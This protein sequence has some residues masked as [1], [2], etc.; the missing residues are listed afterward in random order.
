MISLPSFNPPC[1]KLK[2]E[3]KKGKS[4]IKAF[5]ALSVA[6]SKIEI[7]KKTRNNEENCQEKHRYLR[8]RELGIDVIFKIVF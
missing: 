8:E 6:S 4:Y 3:V 7:D 2:L 1:V 5:P